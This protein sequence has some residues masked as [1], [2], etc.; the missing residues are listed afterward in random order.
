M[1]KSEPLGKLLVLK[2]GLFLVILASFKGV[3]KSA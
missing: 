2:S 3:A 1:L